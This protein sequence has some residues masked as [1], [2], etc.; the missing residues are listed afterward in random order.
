LILFVDGNTFLNVY[1]KYDS[2][3]YNYN[4]I[5]PYKYLKEMF[6]YEQTYQQETFSCMK[7]LDMPPISKFGPAARSNHAL[8]KNKIQNKAI[9]KSLH[10]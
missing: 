3:A 2:I 5:T 8:D 1:L 6:I 10:K 9:Y 4:T 7:R